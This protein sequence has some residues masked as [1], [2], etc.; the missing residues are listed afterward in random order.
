LMYFHATL[1]LLT[2]IDLN[3]SV[4]LLSY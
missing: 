4:N 1:M 3:T 2:K